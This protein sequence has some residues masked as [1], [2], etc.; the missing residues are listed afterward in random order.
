MMY[1]Q[2]IGR[3]AFPEL[4]REMDRLF[5][6][7]LGTEPLAP[8]NGLRPFPALN[9]WEDAER[10]FAEAEMPGLRMDDLEISIQ[11][12]ELA[13]KGRRAPLE[14]DNLVYHRRERG[15]GEFVTLPLDVD[16]DRV[17]ATLKDGVLTIVMP[18]AETARVRKI[19]VKGA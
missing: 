4:R 5:E 11:G 8:S 6:N 14:G 2:R 3:P 10:V 1:L 13:I 19:A 18:K 15:T 17:E 9:L 12:N 16:A 7:F